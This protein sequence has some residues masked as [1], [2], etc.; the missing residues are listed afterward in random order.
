MYRSDDR[1]E[2]RAEA[3]RF[4]EALGAK[5]RKRLGQFF[6][7]VP[8]GKVLAHLALTHDTRTV[9]D[10]MAGHGDL[11]D[12]AAECALE[13]GVVLHRLDGIEIDRTTA[14][15]ARDR[16]ARTVEIPEGAVTMLS[17][18]AFD[19]AV[20]EQLPAAGYDLA[21]TN[22]PYVRYQSGDGNGAAALTVRRDLSSI[23]DSRLSG[24]DCSIWQALIRGYS[25]LADLSVPS[26]L[27][28][29]LL[30]RPGGALA[31][32]VPATWRSRNYGD[33]IRYFMLRCFR[34]RC[35]VEDTQPG[36]FSDALVRTHLIIAT[37]LRPEEIA[38]PLERRPALS[39][40]AW[41][42]IA[43]QAANTG[44]LVG[45]AF[46]GE[47]PEAQLA[48]FLARGSDEPPPGI[49]VTE[50]DAHSEWTALKAK[51][52]QRPWFRGL[53]GGRQ[54]L[55]L[56]DAARTTEQAPLPES[57]RDLFRQLPL[58]QLA[59]LERSGI[60]VGQGL[61]TGCNRFF[62][63]DVVKDNDLTVHVRASPTFGRQ[64]LVVP[65]SAVRPVLRKQAELPDI[66]HGRVPVGRV[67]DLRQWCL[68]EDSESVAQAMSTYRKLGE[69]A[70][71]V[72]PDGLAA[73]VREASQIAPGGEGRTRT[74]ELSAVRTNIRAHRSG[75][76]SPRFWYMLPD[77]MPRHL[78]AA[79]VP[80]VI[81]GSPWAERNLD[82]PILID[83]N[84]ST[85]WASEPTWTGSALKA[86]LNSSWCRLLMEAIG[87][88]MGGGALKLE[89]AHLRLLPVPFFAEKQRR[90]LDELG[91]RLGRHSDTLAGVDEIVVAAL[92]QS[93]RPELVA[94]AMAE[95]GERLR[96]LRRRRAA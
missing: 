57:V 47:L 44:S 20:I 77:F 61:R 73:L 69:A 38:I 86:L 41:L 5:T 93:E 37:R 28:A 75:I 83:A 68:P 78:P 43:P 87:T 94:S 29:G 12:A 16:L 27:L 52:R 31:L 10:P 19:P 88:P 26:W 58:T 62:Y 92:L 42:S 17:G 6:T 70:P 36:W 81:D 95:R 13:R 74:P 48:T 2:A 56:F 25:G 59:P 24:S 7:G 54:G 15:Y 4:E 39:Q 35:I 40:V 67:L 64:E 33:V 63:I 23:A 89:A 14:E 18:S 82:E 66:E 1:H 85:F 96:E 11:L 30:V 72:M 22:P 71:I 65:K 21:I 50:F 49:A 32:V 46:D 45:G 34:V 3:R 51:V 79:F 53:E 76:A 84:F 9:L 60:Q 90:A 80:R 55:P 91:M 8:L